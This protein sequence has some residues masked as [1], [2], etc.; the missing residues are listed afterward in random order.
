MERRPE[1]TVIAGPNGAG[2]SRLCL[3]YVSTTSFDG[4]KLMLKLGFANLMQP[5]NI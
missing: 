3:F 2:K 1:F 4:D 5:I